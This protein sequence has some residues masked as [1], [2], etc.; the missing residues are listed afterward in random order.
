MAHSSR[1]T[2]YITHSFGC[3]SLS[4]LYLSCTLWVVKLDIRQSFGRKILAL[5]I[6]L[7]M[8]NVSLNLDFY[9]FKIFRKTWGRI[10]QEKKY[11][12]K[13]IL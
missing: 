9:L 11:N 13:I 10:E 12:K 4:L 3:F 5:Y 7:E 2:L 6:W 1:D 8:K